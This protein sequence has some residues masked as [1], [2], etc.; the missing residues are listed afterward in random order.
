MKKHFS[1]IVALFFVALFLFGGTI[2]LSVLNPNKGQPDFLIENIT[3][4]VI[5][6]IQISPSARKYPKSGKAF[7]LTDVKLNDRGILNIYLPEDMKKYYMVDIT[8]QCGG[9]KFDAKHPINISKASDFP[10]PGLNKIFGVKYPMFYVEKIDYAFYA[11]LGN[12]AINA[13]VGML[14]SLMP[15]DELNVFF[16]GYKKYR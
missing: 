15:D 5:S 10:I 1:L 16:G 6:E 14:N 11:P 8:V 9:A 7:I 3:G 12:S 2:G 4:S 13:I